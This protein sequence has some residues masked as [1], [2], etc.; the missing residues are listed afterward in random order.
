MAE[1]GPNTGSDRQTQTKEQQLVQR[2]LPRPLPAELV[3]PARWGVV[4]PVVVTPPVEEPTRVE[5]GEEG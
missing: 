3:V 4:P 2:W 1:G 5:A